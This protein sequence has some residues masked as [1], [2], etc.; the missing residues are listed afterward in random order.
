[1]QK[2]TVK[3]FY[4][5][6]NELTSLEGAPKEVK[7]GLNKEDTDKFKKQLEAAGAKVEVK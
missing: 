2:I 7:A 1:L 6:D 3:K 5:N 4:C